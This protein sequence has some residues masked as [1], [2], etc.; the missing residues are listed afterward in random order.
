MPGLSAGYR[1]EN[2][3]KA[4]VLKSGIPRKHT[5]VAG[6]YRYFGSRYS[7]LMKQVPYSG[8]VGKVQRDPLVRIVIG[9]IIT[10]Y[11]E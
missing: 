10:Q 7:Q 6:N 11:A 4:A 3:E 8:S 1:L 5:A 2:M 9:N